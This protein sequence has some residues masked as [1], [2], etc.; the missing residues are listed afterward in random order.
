MQSTLLFLTGFLALLHTDVATADGIR[1]LGR[2]PGRDSAVVVD[3][4]NRPREIRK[5]EVITG[6]GELM[7]IEDDE[8]AVDRAV[9]D[10]E[11]E[12]L[13]AKGLMA[14]DIIRVRIARPPQIDSSGHGDPALVG[15]GVRRFSPPSS[16]PRSP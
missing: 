6:I 11:R 1:Y 7:E 3:D 14:P 4:S 9:T 2:G 13:R 12:Q 15:D 10:E 5:G 8:I 16:D